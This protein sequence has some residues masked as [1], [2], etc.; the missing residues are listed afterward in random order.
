MKTEELKE[1][2][3]K[4]LID[5]DARADW[6]VIDS[7]ESLIRKEVLKGK[8][9]QAEKFINIGYMGEASID[10]LN[11]SIERQV[12]ELQSQLKEIEDEGV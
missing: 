3:L 10:L 9:E 2:I 12:K 8:I 6:E 4:V 11:K 7:I 1:R 5:H